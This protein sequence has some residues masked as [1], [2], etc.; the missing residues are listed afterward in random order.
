MAKNGN[1]YGNGNGGY[2][3]INVPRGE[4]AVASCNKK[5]H[6]PHGPNIP[7]QSESRAAGMAGKHRQIV[8]KGPMVR[9]EAHDSEWSSPLRGSVDLPY[10]FSDYSGE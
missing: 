9:T 5:A 10:Q 3:R 8:D 4:G 1:G 7:D 2:S 6:V